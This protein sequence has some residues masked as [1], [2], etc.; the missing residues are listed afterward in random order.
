MQRPSARKDAG[1]AAPEDKRDNWRM[2]LVS[3]SSARF[4]A[5]ISPLGAELQSL[6]GQDGLEHLWNG[7]AAYWAGRSPIL[8]PVVGMLNGGVFRW[9]GR[10]YPLEKHGFARRRRFTL[11]DH[12]A[13]SATFR[14]V[15]D[16]ATRLS[17]PF[18]F[19]LDLRYE[20]GDELVIAATVFNRGDVPMPFS[21][22]FHPALRLTRPGDGELTFAQRETGPVWRMDDAGLLDRTELLPGNGQTL[23][24]G[25]RLF[26]SDAM[27]LRDVASRSVTLRT[28]ERTI[29]VAWRNLPDLGLWSKP[30]APFLCIEPW[31]GFN[32]PAGFDGM[33]AD[34]PGIVML[35]PDTEWAASMTIEPL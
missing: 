23:E 9:Q 5:T 29:S 15:A 6:T 27:I 10:S 33:I 19:K 34:K 16:E 24:I 32:D 7:D 26:E 30:G 20:L 2:D 22:G 17:Y 18:D 8:F 3:L 14:L 4:A 31:A 13:S 11:V 1:L 35:P 28:G 25:D 12:G 21:F